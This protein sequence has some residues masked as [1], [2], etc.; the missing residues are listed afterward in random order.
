MLGR[1]KHTQST[2]LLKFGKLF[3][4]QFMDINVSIP[5]DKA[6]DLSWQTLADCFDESELL[7]K[8]GLID[9]YFP[10]KLG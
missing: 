4:E 7:M 9:K 5:L 1:K 6:L 2:R 8:Q 3:R 10:K